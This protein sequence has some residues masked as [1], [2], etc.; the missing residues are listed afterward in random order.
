MSTW[1]SPQCTT[2]ETVVVCIVDPDVAVTV[3]CD[4]PDGVTGL[5][6]LSEPQPASAP[7]E[8][9]ATTPSSITRIE[10]AGRFRIASTPP[11]G[12]SSAKKI[13]RAPDGNSLCA[14]LVLSIVSVVIDGALPVAVT[15][16]GEKEHCAPAGSPE[17]ANVTVPVKLFVGAM[18]MVAVAEEP[19]ASL[20][21]PA[22][23]LRPNAGAP[24]EVELAIA[25]K[26]PCCSPASPAVK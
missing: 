17:H 8:T 26:S 13:P 21:V 1:L 11:Y 15:C 19:A 22:D 4:V 10:D 23:A 24:P 6:G 7:S 9:N 18:L 25:P 14:D 3:T 2:S 12:I 20:T 5:T 16:A